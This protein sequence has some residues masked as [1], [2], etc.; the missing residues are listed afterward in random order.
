MP[1]QEDNPLPTEFQV[2]FISKGVWLS[3][4]CNNLS[5]KTQASLP[6]ALI[7]AWKELPRHSWALFVLPESR[8]Y[9]QFVLTPI[10]KPPLHPPKL[11]KTEVVKVWVY[12][13][14][15]EALSALAKSWKTVSV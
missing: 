7:L 14:H 9:Q 4:L 12:G 3:V 10:D 2:P 11:M 5:I 1:R 15:V 8:E 6:L 13:S